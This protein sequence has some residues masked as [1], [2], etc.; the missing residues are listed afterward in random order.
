[1]SITITCEFENPYLAQQAVGKL[2]RQGYTV[3]QQPEGRGAQAL[4]VGGLGQGTFGN[5]LMG[6]L[7]PLGGRGVLLGTGEKALVTVLAQEP[8]RPDAQ[9]LLLSLGGHLL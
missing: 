1:M 5:D 3:S 7:S 8:K 2:R 6:G 4:L 9:K